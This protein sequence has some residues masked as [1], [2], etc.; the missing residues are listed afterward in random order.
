MSVYDTRERWIFN[1]TDKAPVS[2]YQDTDIPAY[3]MMGGLVF[4]KGRVTFDFNFTFS[5]NR[6]DPFR[7]IGLLAVDSRQN[8][9]R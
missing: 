6:T 8:I 9:I 3:T 5:R 2:T 7:D 1:S 4:P